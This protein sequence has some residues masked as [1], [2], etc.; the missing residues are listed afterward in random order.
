M[1]AAHSWATPVGVSSGVAAPAPT[2][3][4]KLIVTPATQRDASLKIIARPCSNA[5]TRSIV[6]ETHRLAYVAHRFGGPLARTSAAL[7]DDAANEHSI[8]QIPLR[9][10]SNPLQLA[11]E[12]IVQPLL[13]LEATD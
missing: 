11:H 8:L 1:A 9:P 2:A 6:I 12:C 4:S 13:S 10:L 3:K 5:V 7:R